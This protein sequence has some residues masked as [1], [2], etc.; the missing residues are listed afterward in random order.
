[1]TIISGEASA[2]HALSLRFLIISY[3]T[4]SVSDLSL[5]K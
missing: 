5:V 2:D 3:S 1:M 4:G